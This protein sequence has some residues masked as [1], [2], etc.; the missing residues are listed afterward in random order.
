MKP[1]NYIGLI[2]LFI[3][4]NS[5]ISEGQII[6]DSSSGPHT[7][8]QDFDVLPSGGTATW[9]DNSSISGWYAT[10]ASSG[11]FAGLVVAT[12]GA[13]GNFLGSFGASS[14]SDRALG[15]NPGGANKA[16][17]IRL[18]NNGATPIAINSMSFTGEQWRVGSSGVSQTV[19]FDYQISPSPI[20]DLSSGTYIA[21]GGLDFTSPVTSP[22]NVNVNGND[23]ANQSALSIGSMGLSI[24]SGSEVMFRWTYLDGAG[25]D[26]NL[27]IDDLSIS[28]A[29][30]PE[31]ST[32]A[33]VLLFVG[34]VVILRQRRRHA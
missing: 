1:A 23:S 3:V 21:L 9:T 18:Q 12:T 34:G 5:S 31:P 6:L 17:G 10:P 27:A 30:V 22:A 26:A 32:W 8:T 2:S 19:T 15:A 25:N 28:Y 16:W 4:G 11:G 29:A 24:A 13:N 14:D 7:Y 33:M 20:T